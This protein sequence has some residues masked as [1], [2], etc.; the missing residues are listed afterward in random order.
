M[1]LA[2]T[3][4]SWASCWVS[5]AFFRLR[6]GNA[7]LELLLCALQLRKLRLIRRKLLFRHSLSGRLLKR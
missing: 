5:S 7:G 4:C 1:L 6:L 2:L 3:L